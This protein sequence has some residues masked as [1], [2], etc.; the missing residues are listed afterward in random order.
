MVQ[1]EDRY[2]HKKTEQKWQKEWIENGCYKASDDKSKP[3]Y[4]VLEMFP[5]PSGKMHM[6]HVR[7]YTLGDVVARYRINQGYNVL[8]PM[9]WDSFGLPAE[10]AAM[11][12]GVH[13]KKW[14]RENIKNMH[15]QFGPL[16]F[17]LDWDREVSTCEKDYFKHEQAMF[18]DFLENDLAYKKE[19]WVNWDPV[20]NTVLANEQVVDGKG[21]RSGVPVERKKLSQWFLRTTAFA[22]DLLSGLNELDRWPERVKTMQNNW[23]GKSYGAQVFF[24]IIG[25]QDNIEV[26]TTRPDTLFGASFCAISAGHP[27]ALELAEKN[28]DVADFI[29]ECDKIGT[30]EADIEKAEK[31]GFDTGL[32]AKH[33]FPEEFKALGGNPELPIYIANF[34]LMEYGTGAVFACPAHDQRD[35]DFARKYDL[36]VRTVIAP[37]DVD[38]DEFVK[39]HDKSNEAYTDD[40]IVV[41][42]SFLTNMKVKQATKEVIKRLEEKNLGTGKVQFR[43]RDWGVSRQRYWGAPVPIIKCDSCG[44]VPV[45]KEDLP[46]ELPEDVDFKKP[47]NPLEN[48]P[49]WK[50]VKCPKCGKDAV[51][52]TDTF[53]TFFESSWYFL[54]YCSPHL[55]DKAFNEEDVNYWLP[56]DQYIGGI[57]HAVMHLLYARF[58]TRALEK[59]GYFKGLKEPF[60]GLFTQGMICHETYRAKDGDWLYPSEIEKQSDDK[61]IRISDG[62]EVEV[63]RSEKMSK[64]KQN[65]V[66]PEAIIDS[67]GA[68]AA[69]LFML[70]DSPPDRDLEWTESGI[71]GAWRYINKLWRLVCDPNVEM[72]TKDAQMPEKMAKNVDKILRLAHKTIEAVTDDYE[73]LRFNTAVARI[74][75]LTN[76][77]SDIKNGDDGASYVYRFVLETIVRLAS[78]MIPHITEEMWRILGHDGFLMETSW[79]KAV[80]ELT[81]D[82]S[83]TVAVQVKGKMRGTIELPKDCDQ[84]LAQ[85]EALKL[86]TVQNQI[87]GKEIKKIIVVPNRIV[88]IV[89]I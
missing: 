85:E 47:G 65:T 76:S 81:V 57:E 78:P 61:V 54:R 12:R 87:E 21:W 67:Y 70:S 35:L 20:E 53:D 27:L 88:N 63:G 28:K 83:V 66:D 24:P 29:K 38:A 6:G 7:N 1:V 30:S 16:G 22:D 34:V 8:H 13:P 52:E 79:P 86:P 75:E 55:Q 41:N 37:S 42:S 40:G 59:C 74:R 89:A 46:V 69:R 56:V 5:Y 43:L 15:T 14:T 36:P 17:S 3:K 31:I 71:D 48:H 44:M 26:Y 80:K 49:T 4:Y 11:K 64:S 32:K 19:S 25:R 50:N 84:K 82:N 58:F 72:A 39:E 18:I 33:P 9:G 77:L 62:Q 23:I 10:N 60:D 45:P 68:D 51:R 2:N 73:K